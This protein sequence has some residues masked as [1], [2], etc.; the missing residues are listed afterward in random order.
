MCVS[1]NHIQFL[2]TGVEPTFRLFCI[3]NISQKMD[4]VEHNNKL[5]VATVFIENCWK[6]VRLDRDINHS[7]NSI[8]KILS[9]PIPSALF[10]P[11]TCVVLC[12]ICYRRNV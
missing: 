7:N 8:W 12:K 9:E 1:L 3:T 6:F 4:I 5:T 2:K 10:F 11:I